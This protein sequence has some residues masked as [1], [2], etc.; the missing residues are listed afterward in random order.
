MTKR[1]KRPGPSEMLDAQVAVWLREESGVVPAR[2]VRDQK[3]HR[4]EL[5][6]SLYANYERW[7][8]ERSRDW[9]EGK[10]GALPVFAASPTAFYRALERAGLDRHI[11]AD[12][13]CF[14][15]AKLPYPSGPSR[16][17]RGAIT[18]TMLADMEREAANSMKAVGGREGPT[19]RT[20]GCALPA[21]GDKI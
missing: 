13:I 6:D 9:E 3:L 10:P 1:K 15:C 5:A 2:D 16:F 18:S 4:Y 17:R 11:L 19:E 7:C 21:A 14:L 8:N 12:H 20:D